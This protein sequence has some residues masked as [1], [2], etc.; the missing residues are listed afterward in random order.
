[1]NKREITF[2]GLHLRE[3]ADGGKSRTVVGHAVVFGQMSINLTPWSS[4]REMY[5]V[6]ERGAITQELL[7][8]SD[9]ML[10]AFHD[11]KMI[12]GRCT[13]GRGTLSL[14]LDERGLRAECTLAETATAD[15]LLAAIERGDIT[16]MSFAFR[17]DEDDSENG[18]SYE[19][20]QPSGSKEVYLRHVKKI[21]KLYDVTIAG[22]PAYPQTDIAQREADEFYSAAIGEPEALK[23]ERERQAE[24][25]RL[26][27]EK[28]QAE[29]GEA[30][31]R[32]M[33]RRKAEMF[34]RERN[35]Y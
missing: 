26:A 6:I 15:E 11:N 8:R 14:V 23:L 33:N 1:M 30:L 3:A 5:E 7:D 27:D 10:T 2:D 12:L 28:R 25:Q 18:V 34:E 35:I 24:E 29:E 9:V 21:D 16:G 32:E 17:A 19:K 4:Y 31:A 22:R 20:L 13:N